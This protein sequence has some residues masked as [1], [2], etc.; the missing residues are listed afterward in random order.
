MNF[1]YNTVLESYDGHFVSSYMIFV[2]CSSFCA[3]P[4]E[5]GRSL[6]DFTNGNGMWCAVQCQVQTVQFVKVNSDK[7]PYSVCTEQHYPIIEVDAMSNMEQMLHWVQCMAL[8]TVNLSLVAVT[9][10]TP[11]T[12]FPAARGVHFARRDGHHPL[13]Q[14]K[15]GCARPEAVYMA[16]LAPPYLSARTISKHCTLWPMELPT[17]SLFC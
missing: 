7:M 1:P 5:T 8:N 4:N 15:G 13:G 16:Q 11:L 2:I 10:S 3:L 6:P 9:C 17:S 12:G 14:V